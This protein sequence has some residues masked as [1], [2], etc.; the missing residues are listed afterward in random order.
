ML[1]S[2]F[3]AYDYL[4]FK[5]RKLKFLHRSILENKKTIN[6]GHVC[7]QGPI[8]SGTGAHLATSHVRFL[9]FLSCFFLIFFY[10]SSVWKLLWTWNEFALLFIV[11]KNLLRTTRLQTSYHWSF[12]WCLDLLIYMISYYKTL[13]TPMEYHDPG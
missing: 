7:A 2:L 13:K 5:I 9:A 1:G 11:F 3:I 12:T 6:Y 10:H 8:P 4:G